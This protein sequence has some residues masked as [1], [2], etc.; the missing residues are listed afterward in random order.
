M[1]VACELASKYL[2]PAIRAMVATKLV[3][4]YGLSQ[5]EVAK[6]L[7]TTQP[8]I[9]Y[10]L[11]SLRGGK[12]VNALKKKR[13]VVELINR[14]AAYIAENRDDED[15]DL[16]ELVCKICRIVREDEALMRAFARL[17]VKEARV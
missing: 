14:M 5:V 13:E 9:S 12:A 6:R 15:M 7:R 11:R 1:R 2:V 17:E 16:E 8:A 3:R 4:E 10:Y